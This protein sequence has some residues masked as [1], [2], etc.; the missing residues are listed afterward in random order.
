[1]SMPPSSSLLMTAPTSVG[2][3]ERP[4]HESATGSNGSQVVVIPRVCRAPR[5]KINAARFAA[6][7]A[8][9]P[10]SFQV[11]GVRH[12]DHKGVRD[13][14]LEIDLLS[15]GRLVFYDH[16]EIR[17]L[18]VDGLAVEIRYAIGSVS[19]THLTLPTSDLV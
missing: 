1:M 7:T 6:L 14:Y 10:D 19:Y 16:V 12:G 5:R 15:G 13:L 17:A 3:R 8:Y 9:E 18:R 11:G 2:S 4:L